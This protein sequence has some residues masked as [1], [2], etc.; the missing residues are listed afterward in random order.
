MKAQNP[1]YWTAREF[2]LQKILTEQ[3]LCARHCEPMNN[4]PAC[5]RVSR[6]ITPRFL[7]QTFD[8]LLN[9]SYEAVTTWQADTSW[10]L[11]LGAAWVPQGRP[12]ERRG[13][14]ARSLPLLSGAIWSQGKVLSA[15]SE[16]LLLFAALE[17]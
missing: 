3:L 10:P 15:G 4:S 14:E 13:G 11:G 17:H 5:K 16:T 7:T 6:S 8:E 1:N 12:T 9:I 2:P